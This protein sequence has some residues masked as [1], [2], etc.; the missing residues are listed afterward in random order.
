MRLGLGLLSWAPGLI[1]QVLLIRVL[2]ELGACEVGK[3]AKGTRLACPRPR[4]PVLG[5]L[6]Q[7]LLAG[8]WDQRSE[9]LSILLQGAVSGRGAPKGRAVL[10]RET[11]GAKVYR[12]GPRRG[13]RPSVVCSELAG[14]C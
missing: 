1:F 5:V 8:V 6:H 14:P 11:L 12:G 9:R 10:L 7:P 4:P 3:D 13:R 2:H